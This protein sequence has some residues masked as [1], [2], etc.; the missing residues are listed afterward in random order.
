LSFIEKSLD[1]KIPSIRI[2][3]WLGYAGGFGFDVL[4][5]I[6]RKKLAVSSVRVRKFVAT[7][8]FDASKV[9]SSGFRAPYTLEEGLDRTL[10]Y[11]FVQERSKND[12]VF[13]TE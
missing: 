11:E 4:S 10:K 7:T 2:P 6:F 13:Y 1:K 9:H 8:Q 12:E 5:F 3:K